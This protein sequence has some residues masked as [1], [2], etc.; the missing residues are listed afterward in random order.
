MQR[1]YEEQ[2]KHDEIVESMANKFAEQGH[3]NIKADI[4]GYAKPEQ[5][6]YHIPDVTSEE[7]FKTHIVE[8]ETCSSIDDSHTT[9][10]WKTFNNTDAEFHIAVPEQCLSEAKQRAEQIGVKAKFWFFKG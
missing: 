1:R 7:G 3:R 2:S 9:S 8:V 6:G 10:Q 4:D 5:I